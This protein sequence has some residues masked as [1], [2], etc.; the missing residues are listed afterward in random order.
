VQ[1]ADL[2]EMGNQVADKEL[3]GVFLD[4]VGK[5]ILFANLNKSN[6]MGQS[7]SIS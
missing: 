4:A 7:R 3:V 5:K 6:K 1:H 2:I